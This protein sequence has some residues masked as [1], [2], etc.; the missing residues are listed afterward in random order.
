MHNFF[1][2]LLEG[3]PVC[4]SLLK[5]TNATDLEHPKPN[6][7]GSKMKLTTKKMS[8]TCQQYTKIRKLTKDKKKL[9]N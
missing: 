4:F 8:D 1:N 2:F 3:I 7:E 6:N 5:D 9:E